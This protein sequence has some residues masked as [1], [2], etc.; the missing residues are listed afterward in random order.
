M[1][2]NLVLAAAVLS[3]LAAF[4]AAAS[5]EVNGKVVDKDGKP[6]VDASIRL[7]NKKQSNL[8][9][10]VTS[11]KKG[12]F[13][14]PNVFFQEAA[15]VWT[16][17]CTAPSLVTTHVKIVGRTAQKVIYDQ[18]DK[19]VA[20]GSTVDI[21]IE[22]LAEVKVDF[23]MGPPPPTE[24]VIPTEGV[25]PEGAET[26]PFVQ[27]KQKVATQDFEGAAELLR[28]SIEA[29]PDDAERREL[30]SKVLYKLDRSGEALI[31]ANKAAEIAPD[32]VGP[33]LLLADLH[34]ARGNKEKAALALK[35]ARELDPKN[36]KVLDRMGSNALEQ[37]R[38]DDA[39]EAFEALVAADA[40]HAEG[41]MSLGNAY[42][43]KGQPDKAEAAFRKVVELSPQN[44]HEVF[45]NLGALI[46]NRPEITDADNRKSI[47]AFRKAIEIK[48]D[49][50]KAHRHLGFALLRTGDLPAARKALQE[51]LDLAPNA[52]DAPE[53]RA[54]VKELAP[55]KSPKK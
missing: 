30:Y 54:T 8:D 16:I 18:A 40:T 39:I 26:D 47:E 50:A 14:I 17:A 49:Y 29:K 24:A 28:A 48:P 51:Y 3:A 31:Q 19:D 25:V 43:Q 11:D 53:I 7:T 5:T 45:F 15:K 22:A 41:W 13:F 36:T 27:A 1:R 55:A 21:K 42:N 46:E 32:R 20:P 52:S 12:M 10:T 35:R 34:A 9:Y 2:H 23:T 37:G 33:Q 44:A 6:I 4:P 38:I